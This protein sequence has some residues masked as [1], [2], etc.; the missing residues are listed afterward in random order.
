MKS[1]ALAKL[2]HRP[3]D[4]DRGL[5]RQSRDPTAIVSAVEAVGHRFKLDQILLVG[6]QGATRRSMFDVVHLCE[7]GHP[8]HPGHPGERLVAWRTPGS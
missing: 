7:I 3:P 6:G 4:L 8:D 1:E 5:R 2:S